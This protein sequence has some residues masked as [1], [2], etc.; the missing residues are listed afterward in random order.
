MREGANHNRG[1]VGRWGIRSLIVFLLLCFCMVL[2]VFGQE[3]GEGQGGVTLKLQYVKDGKVISGAAFRMYHAADFSDSVYTPTEAFGAY[4]VDWN[5]GT[6]ED[7]K[8]LAETLSGYVRRDQL[9]PM[10]EGTVDETGTLLLTSDIQSPALY[11]VLGDACKLDGK[12]YTPEPFLI[13]LP[14]EMEEGDEVVDVAPKSTSTGGDTP[15][16]PD[17]P[18]NPD[19]PGDG[20]E[21]HYISRKV[22]KVWKDGS[23]TAVHPESIEVQLLR[24]GTIYDTVTLNAENGWTHTWSGLQEGASWEIVEAVVPAGYTVSLRREGVT[25]VLTN[26][27]DN[28]GDDN[29][30]GGDNPPESDTPEHPMVPGDGGDTPETPQDSKLPQTGLLW[31]PVPVLAGAGLVLF[32]LGWYKSRRRDGEAD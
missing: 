6:S 16:N 13:L 19:N 10:S 14:P 24:N 1:R 4:Q 20:G 12:T 7:W 17:N 26:T 5:P 3:T 29:P 32:G 31:W 30:P 18:D 9:T 11:L 28:P 2:T 25:V 22:L 23:G 27:R 8:A 15:E 21:D